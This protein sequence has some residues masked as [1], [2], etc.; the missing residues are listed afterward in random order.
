M[1]EVEKKAYEEYPNSSMSTDDGKIAQLQRDAYIKGATEFCRKIWA[2]INVDITKNCV[3]HY[4]DENISMAT[5]S[6]K[7]DEISEFCYE[8]YHEVNLNDN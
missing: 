2:K 6:D 3:G 5:Y 7:L 4:L 1:T 8:Q